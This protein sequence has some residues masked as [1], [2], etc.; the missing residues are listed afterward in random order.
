MKCELCHGHE[1]ETVLYRKGKD[2]RPEE[3]YVCRACAERERAFGEDRGV[4]VATLEAGV[5][6]SSGNPGK[7][8]AGLDAL[9]LPPKEVLGQLSEMFGKLS[10]KVEK[11]SATERDTCPK[12][13]TTLDDLRAGQPMGCPVCYQ[14]FGRVLSALLED[15]QGCTEYRGEPYPGR[16]GERKLKALRAALKAAVER[17]DYAAA[18]KLRAEIQRL[19]GEEGRKHG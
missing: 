11:A 6:S 7:F 10:E 8:P 9:G 18:A 17:E 13:G 1:A 4:N 19:E 16:E 2:D 15:L 14:T 12:C 5:P 3:L